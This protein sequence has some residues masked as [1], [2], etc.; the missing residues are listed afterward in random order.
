MLESAEPH[1]ATSQPRASGRQLSFTLDPLLHKEKESLH[2]KGVK[3]R[4][5]GGALNSS[6]NQETLGLNLLNPQQCHPSVSSRTCTWAWMMPR[7]RSNTEGAVR[8]NW[9]NPHMVPHE[10]SLPT[11]SNKAQF[12]DRSRLC[13]CAT[14]SSAAWCQR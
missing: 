5:A 1:F 6:V 2:H 10:E 12:G 14:T 11:S 13:R 4:P 3:N 7:S 9:W 8:W